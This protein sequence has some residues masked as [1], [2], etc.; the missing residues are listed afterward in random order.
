MFRDYGNIEEIL[1]SD[2]QPLLP[3]NNKFNQQSTGSNRQYSGE[4]KQNT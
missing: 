3:G 4:L 1:K 2:C